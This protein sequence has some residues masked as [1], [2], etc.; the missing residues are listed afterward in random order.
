LFRTQHKLQMK[1]A[2]L[3]KTKVQIMELQQQMKEKEGK[4]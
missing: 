4:T 2:E 1:E 3:M